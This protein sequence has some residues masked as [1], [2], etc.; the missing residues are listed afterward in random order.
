MTCPL[1]SEYLEYQ[2]E[3]ECRHDASYIIE[4]K[5]SIDTE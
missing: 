3:E 2:W 4:M 5:D 1:V